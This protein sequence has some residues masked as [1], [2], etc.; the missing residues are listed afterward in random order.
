MKQNWNKT[1][2][3]CTIGPACETDRL[4]QRLVDAGMDI[5]RFNFSHGTIA[6]QTA[7]MRRVRSLVRRPDAALGIMQDLPGPKIRIGELASECIDLKKGQLFTLTGTPVLGTTERVSLLNRSFLSGLRPKY[8]VYLNDGLVRMIVRRVSRAGVL[9]EVIAGGRV[10]PRKG[11]SCPQ[12]KLS[13]SGVTAYDLRCVA[14]GIRAGV[15]YVAISFVQD[16][17][18]V[19]RVK[20]YLQARG[21]DAMVIAKIERKVALEDLDGIVRASDAIMVARGDLGVEADLEQIPVLQKEIIRAANAQGKPVITATQ[22]LDSMVHNPQPTRAEVTDIA[23]AILDGTDAIMLS[24]ETAVGAYPVECVQTMVRIAR[25]TELHFSHGLSGER[26]IEGQGGASAKTGGMPLSMMFSAAAVE[27][28]ARLQARIIV[29]PT[30]NVASIAWL[31][32]L[33]P[34]AIIVGLTSDRN[35]YQKL[36]LYWGAFPVYVP[37]PTSLSATLRQCARTVIAR[38][39][40]RKGQPLVVML[41][42]DNHL[43]PANRIEVKTL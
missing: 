28:A 10:Y 16:S 1:K 42:D 4:V 7:R 24:E 25:A 9:C 13:G 18:D 39:L 36:L 40:G 34:G 20:R 8:M 33:R 14:A 30:N 26:V 3:V 5:A 43:F 35:T 2:I 19:R 23:N 37:H 11:V 31:S 38:K 27:I 32:A 15:D 21:S 22:M 17:S 29:A 12:V 41:T 6:E